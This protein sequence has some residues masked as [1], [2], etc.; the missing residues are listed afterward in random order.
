MGTKPPRTG[1]ALIGSGIGVTLAALLLL[2]V[3]DPSASGPAGIVREVAVSGVIAGLVVSVMG[4]LDRVPA[5]RPT[6]ARTPG[7][8]RRWLL[9]LVLG[10]V[11]LALALLA[12]D[13]MQVWLHVTGG[14]ALL[15]YGTVLYFRE[16]RRRGAGSSPGESE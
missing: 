10:V 8:G 9:I 1:V 12:R 13:A 6:A 14:A 4:A 2:I 15:A 5:F 16:G 7:H 3:I 11:S